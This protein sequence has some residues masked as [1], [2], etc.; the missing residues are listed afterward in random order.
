M[1]ILF[2]YRYENYEPL[3]MMTLSAVLKKAGHQCSYV[4][5]KFEINLIRRVKDLAPD[6]I[7]YSLITGNHNYF[8]E[9]NLKLKKHL[10]FLSV[11]GG[12]HCTLFPEFIDEEGVDVICRGEAENAM[13]ILADQLEKGED[14]KAIPNMWVKKEGAIYKNPIEALCQNLDDLPFPD[15]DLV[16]VYAHYRK[17]QRRDVISLRGCPYQCTYC[18]NHAFKEIYKG[19][20]AY[21]RRRSVDNL[22]Q[23]LKILKEEYGAKVFH[24]QDD[25]FIIN[26]KWT[27]K[28]CE[29]FK[30]EIGLQFEVQVRVNHIDEEIVRALKNAGCV[31]ALYGVESGNEEIRRDLLKRDIS[32]AQIL[33]VAALFRKY[34]IRTMSVNMLGLPDE[35]FE[36]ALE[37]LDLNIKCI[38][39]YAWNSI[40]QPYPKTH[41]AQY[42]IDKGYFKGDVNQFNRSFLY[43]TSLMEMRDIQRI[44][45]LH[46]LFSL[47][48]AVPCLKN[49]IVKMTKYPFNALFRF[50]FFMHR[51]YAAF[52][53][54][55][56]IRIKEVLV[57]EKTRY[58]YI[59]KMGS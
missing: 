26:K 27:F 39:H 24:F 52:F 14:I 58:F 9:I 13:K 34:K 16:N 37:T 11:F 53:S 23:E 38:P 22:I 50:L 2:I 30:K 40:Y 49:I 35:R 8:K 44:I 46:Y 57:F 43:G 4:D 6:I 55:K 5:T 1:K 41:L 29:R 10:S 17:M 54:L 48:V 3:G 32:D 47:A 15:R 59:K 36:N 45:R 7:A 19:K 28:F 18:Y 21:V 20:G 12:P 42:A 31:W 56:R 51:V 25:L 33:N